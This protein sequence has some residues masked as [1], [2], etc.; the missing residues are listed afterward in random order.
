M[1]ESSD[2]PRR[3]S[4]VVLI[5]DGDF[6][7]KLVSLFFTILFF[8]PSHTL[9]CCKRETTR[10][11]NSPAIAISVSSEDEDDDDD[12]DDDGDDDEDS[13]QDRVIKGGFSFVK[14]MTEF[15]IGRRLDIPRSCVNEAGIKRTMNI[16][17]KKTN[18]S[19]RLW[20]VT[21]TYTTKWPCSLSSGGWRRFVRE[22]DVNVGDT[23]RFTF[24]A[25]ENVMEV[26]VLKTADEEEEEE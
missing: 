25:G 13:G 19:R 1:V 15:C 6:V 21:L 7:D 23:V 20:P 24:R 26:R 8:L 11:G 17:L 4:F 22:N 10:S 2:F 3:S 5:N 14:K 18:G 16:H 12:G 9:S